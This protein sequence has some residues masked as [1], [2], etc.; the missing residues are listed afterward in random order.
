MKKV[1]VLMLAVLL[2]GTVGVT[3][4]KIFD[5]VIIEGPLTLT[6]T[7]VVSFTGLT[8]ALDFSST[9][10]I[11]GAASVDLTSA[12]HVDLESA[13]IRL[14]LDADDY[15]KLVTTN[16]TAD[17]S[18]SHPGNTGALITWTAGGWTLTG[19]FATDGTTAQLDGSTSV[20]LVSN[21][22]AGVECGDIRLGYDASDYMKIAVATGTGDVTITHTGTNKAVSWTAAGGFS[23]AGEFAMNTNK[24][25]GAG[26]PTA[27]QDL[28]TKAYV[29]ATAQG[30]KVH[31]AVACATTANISLSAEQTLDG[32]LTSTDRVLVKDQTAP[33]ENGIYVSAGG[34][35]V[36]A[37]DMDV[38]TE[39]AGSFVFVSD[40]T[41][42][43]CTGWTCTIE[44]EDFTL[45]TTAMPWSQFSD[46]GY[47]TA[48]GG[49]T[50]TGNNVAP[51]G[52]LADLNTSGEVSGDNYVLAST[53]AGVVVWET[54]D[55]LRTSL[56]LAIS[57]NVQAWDTD[58]DTW[59][60][61]TPTADA[62]TLV[63]STNFLSMT[64]DL[65]VEIGVDVQ[66][67]D[68]QLDDIAA[69]VQ[70]D[71]YIIVGD[72]SN[73][74]QETG[75]TARSSLGVAIDSDVQA[76]SADLGT[77]ATAASTATNEGVVFISQFAIAHTQTD[78]YTVCIVP[79]NADV[80]K[81]EI[82]TTTAFTGGSATTIDVGY[83]GTLEAYASDLDIRSAGFADCDVFS[84]LGD[85]GASDVTMKA[86]IATDDS[87]GACIV[88]IYWT[89][90]TPGTP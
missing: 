61:L 20:K 65:S 37:G 43:G 59:A 67:W 53:G 68:T 50:K 22:L 49:L 12:G 85:V 40:G 81:V 83:V 89:M 60:T 57:T 46:A 23:W 26:D 13:D 51:D 47:I 56:G 18:I 55:T 30:L 32:I 24:I 3:Q 8:F 75:A 35:W 4:T 31:A 11:D 74:V 58:L 48:S 14:G 33:A 76:Y 17:L 6:G 87:A 45:G 90:G 54:G 10:L 7:S 36:R 64:Q 9:V 1:F 63:E 42:L 84:N 62:Q 25:T 86:Q 78:S 70:S 77:I 29:D 79:A 2:L 72:D 39:V 44:P 34:A 82:A 52:N 69:L 80:T 41:T 38:S 73:W 21:T 71:S 19:N 5:T 27:A 88:Y 16:S 28:A 15:M 66:A